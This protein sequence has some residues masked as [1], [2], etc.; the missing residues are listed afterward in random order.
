[1][2][3]NPAFFGLYWVLASKYNRIAFENPD[4]QSG[5]KSKNMAIV[6]LNAK[7]DRAMLFANFIFATIMGFFYMLVRDKYTNHFW[8]Y[9]TYGVLTVFDTILILT[10]GLMLINSVVKIS[11]SLKNQ[12]HEIN[13]KNLTVHAVSF[14]IFVAAF[15]FQRSV[16]FTNCWHFA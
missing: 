8:V 2:V 11:Q 14:V 6:F 7:V 5:E 12:E 10:S 9:Q 13:I 15:I 4:L 16:L 3:V 1:M